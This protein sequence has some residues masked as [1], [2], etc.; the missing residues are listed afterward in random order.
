MVSVVSIRGGV[1]AVGKWARAWWSAFAQALSTLRARPVRTALG[2]LATAVAVA[3]VVAVTTALDGVA[4]FATRT[5]ERAFGSNTFLIA[6]VASPTRVSRRELQDQLRRNPPITRS[7]LRFLNRYAEGLVAYA[8]NAQAVADVVSGSRVF[9]RAAITGTTAV[10]SEL[11]DLGISRGR[12]FADR[13]DQSGQAVAVIGAD[14]AE[15]LFPGTDPLGRAVRLAN[16]RFIVIGVQDRLGN[17]GGAS[18][19]RYVWIPL[20]AFERALGVPRSLQI[21]ARAAEGLPSVVGE[22]RARV[23]LRAR[24]TLRPGAADT[25]D[26]LTPDAARTFVQT[27]SERIGV[28]ALPIAFAALLT[29]VVVVTNT[30]L[31]SVTERTREIGVRRALGATARQVR[32]EVIAEALVTAVAG[33]LAGALVTA[34]AVGAVGRFTP[35]P[36][37]VSQTSFALSLAISALAGLVA[38]WYPARRA[39]RADVITAL[40][41]E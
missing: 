24:R 30:V 4:L 13:E 8:P 20:L 12:F 14:V 10:L 31:V 32:R 38:A 33:G 39:T 1:G 36:V 29:A 34:V 21:F 26:V 2:A 41:V 40:R 22:D 5:S 19:D 23:S 18:L 15:A 9:E 27:L 7:E 3:G 6:Q 35:V 17:S 37:A 16:R 25:F 28:A 11:R